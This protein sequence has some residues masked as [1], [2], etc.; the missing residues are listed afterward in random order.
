MCGGGTVLRGC[1]RRD[2][3]KKRLLFRLSHQVW[4]YLSFFSLSSSLFLPTSFLRFYTTQAGREW[5]HPE[6]QKREDAL[7]V[8][9]H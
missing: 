5:Q 4:C 7:A 8:A 1:L 3:E 9:L 2:I 6:D